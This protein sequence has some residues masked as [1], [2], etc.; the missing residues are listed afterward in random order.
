MYLCSRMKTIYLQQDQWEPTP[1][2]ATIGTFDGVHQGHRFVISCLKQE[3]ER[4]QLPSCVITFDRHPKSAPGHLL[5]TLDEKL[6]LLSQTDIDLCVVLPFHQ[7]MAALSAYD[8]MQEVLKQQLS[9]RMLLVGY[10]NH[11]GHRTPGKT[12]HFADY[13]RYGQQLGID[14]QQLPS[15]PSHDGKTVNSSVIRQLL[16]EGRIEEANDALG[17]PYSI[18]GTVVS[19]EHIG[20]HLGFPTANLQPNDPLKLIPANGVYAVKVR[21]ESSLEQKHAM[22]N[23]GRRPTFDGSCTTLETHILRHEGELY[24]QQIAVSFIHR[25]RDEQRFET[26][27]ALAEQ[28]QRD[29]QTAEELLTNDIDE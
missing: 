13:Q 15:A 5:T 23:I 27:E 28:L 22:A 19:G 29:A 14:V 8:F 9:V 7:E 25:L 4:L 11:F 2:V 18:T 16:S 20:T 6:M 3:A 24:G 17:F 10:D 26:P 1:C 12:E 21:L